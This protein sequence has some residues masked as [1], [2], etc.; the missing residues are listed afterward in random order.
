[1][2][3]STETSFIIK[4]NISIFHAYSRCTQSAKGSRIRSYAGFSVDFRSFIF[5]GRYFMCVF[6]CYLFPSEALNILTIIWK[7]AADMKNSNEKGCP[8]EK[9]MTRQYKICLK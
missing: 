5:S 6:C 9:V 7:T 2:K 3:T 8:L 4:M 1:M